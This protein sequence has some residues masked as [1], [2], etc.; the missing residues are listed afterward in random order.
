MTAGKGSALGIIGAWI[1]DAVNGRVFNTNYTADHFIVG[2]DQLDDAGGTDRDT[3][4]WFNKTKGAVRAGSVTSTQ[5]D[6]ASV[7]NQSVAFGLNTT[8]SGG[9]SFASG[10]TASATNTE[11]FAQ[12][13]GTASGVGAVAFGGATASGQRSFAC[14]DSTASGI[15]AFSAGNGTTAS[16]DYSTAT[17]IAGTASGRSSSIDGEQGVA[18]RYGQHSQGGYFFSAQGD[19]QTN[20]FIAS[21]ISTSATAVVLFFDGG[22]LTSNTAT[23]TGA[24]TNVLTIPV[25]RAHQVTMKGMARR[26]DTTGDYA[27]FTSTFTIIR[28]AAGNAAFITA[29]VVT[30][31]ATASAI[32][33]TLVPTIDTSNATNNYLVLTATGEAAKTIRWAVEIATVEVG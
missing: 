9:Q 4:M 13:Q 29:P 22:A 27:S 16:G 24:L 11:A 15:D 5:W 14:C 32:T 17:G 23:L 19:R 20:R 18:L 33:W 8:A 6:N 25:G 31:D 21:R 3:R 2:S 26:T 7:G 30:A 28:N 10:N 12:G 1:R